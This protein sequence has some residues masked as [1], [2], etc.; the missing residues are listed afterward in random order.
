MNCTESQCSQCCIKIYS[1]K[2]QIKLLDHLCTLA[3]FM[4]LR[5]V[6]NKP[7]YRC[8]EVTDAYLF[9]VWSLLSTSVL[10]GARLQVRRLLLGG[11]LVS[12]TAIHVSWRRVKQCVAPSVSKTFSDGFVFLKAPTQMAQSALPPCGWKWKRCCSLSYD[13]EIFHIQSLVA[14]WL[15]EHQDS[16][17]CSCN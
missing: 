4:L 9:P 2:L 7:C 16:F 11:N 6:E 5:N 13:A 3:V 1:Y 17:I 14:L 10:H 8:V 15:T 12:R